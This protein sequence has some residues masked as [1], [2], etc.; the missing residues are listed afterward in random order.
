VLPRLC[1]FSLSADGNEINVFAHSHE[2]LLEICDVVL[3]LLAASAV[4]SVFLSQRGA[5]NVLIN[6]PTLAY[7]MERCKRLRLLSLNDM[8][9]D[10]NHCRVLGDYLRPGLDIKVSGC[11]LTDAGTSTL[12]EVLG[13]NQGP[14]K[15]DA[16]STDYSVLANGLRGN[17]RLKSF[18]PRI[19][20][21]IDVGNRELLA[22]A[23]APKA[24]LNW[25]LVLAISGRATKRGAPSAI[26][27][28]RI[29]HSRS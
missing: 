3:R 29:R 12:A 14:T 7:L 4:H 24:S 15:L 27:S 13:R 25:I 8:E 20:S 1:Y 28:R 6:A 21:I 18:R 10:E 26:L 9:M 22:I 2:H 16:C 19:S 17:S 23:D 5:L 11:K